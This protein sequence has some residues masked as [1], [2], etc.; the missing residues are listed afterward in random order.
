MTT[1]STHGVSRHPG[2]VVGLPCLVLSL[3]IAGCGGVDSSQAA[4]PIAASVQGTGGPNTLKGTYNLAVIRLNDPLTG[5]EASDKDVKD[6]LVQ[7]GLEPASIALTSFDAKGD[8]AAVP[9]LVDEAVRAG[10][11]LIITLRPETTL[12]AAAKES[13]VPL[14][15][16]MTG[17]PNVFGLGKHDG[18]HK[19]NLT[20]AYTGARNSLIVPIVRGCLPE[21]KTCGVLFNA[22]NPVSVGWK[23]ALL[24]TEWDKVK[25]EPAPYHSDSEV[26]SVVRA[27]LEKK[28]DALIITQGVSHAASKA[29]IDEARKA[30]VPSFGLHADHARSGAVVAREPSP[31]WSGFEAGRRAARVLR[32]EAPK[33]ITFVQGDNYLTYVNLNEAKALGVK[34]LGAIMRDPKLVE[35]DGAKPSVKP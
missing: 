18:D 12:A 17:E 33:Q 20:G 2:G 11:D 25:P 31:R 34:I 7:A 27:L 23:D 3:A 1:Q 35:T 29:A 26:P 8:P 24:R 32:G 28:V 13:K 15:F 10:S 14:V 19:P 22:D 30:K 16:G 9:G 21:A 5:E 6:G 4:K